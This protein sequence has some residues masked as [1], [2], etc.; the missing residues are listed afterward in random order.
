[1]SRLSKLYDAMDT[2]RKESLSNYELEAKVSQ[3]EEE[4][5]KKE[6]LPIVEQNIAPALQ[7]VQREMVLVVEYK[8]GQPIS[9]SLSRKVKVSEI[10]GLKRITPSAPSPRDVGQPVACEDPAADK[11]QDKE[12][13][14]QVTNLTKGLRVTFA[15]GTVICLPTAI[16]T[17]KAVLQRIGLGRVHRLGIK[18][19]DY[20]LV[21]HEMRPLAPNRIFQH[22]LDGWY[23]YS[24]MS[25]KDKK[26]DLQAISDRLGLHLKIEE[27]KPGKG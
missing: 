9:V 14:K 27:G 4:I 22:T 24:N 23:I 7:E 5:I 21:G 19:N 2:I 18:H 12:P 13:T 8:P 6:I 11:P 10:P 16:D 1:M 3:A 26:R 15:D 17:F 25:N 20:N